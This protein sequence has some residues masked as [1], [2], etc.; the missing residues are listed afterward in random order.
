MIKD[1]FTLAIKN[2]RKRGI[3]SWL[4]LLGIIIGVAVVVSLVFLGNGLKLAVMNQFGMDTTE[5]ISVQAGGLSAFGP[6]GTGV[7]NPLTIKDLEEI[8]KLSSVKKAIRRNIGSV[9]TKF[10]GKTTISFVTNVPLEERR[11]IQEIGNIEIEKG[12][13]FEKSDSRKV[14]LGYNF[15]VGKTSLTDKE[16]FPGN[17]MTINDEKYEVIG[18]TKR[19]GSFIQDN[20]IFMSNEDMKR[21]INYEDNI[22]IIAVQPENAQRM[23]DSV[24]D[25]ERILRKTRNVKEGEEDF[26]VST[27]EASLAMIN[28]IITGVQ[29]FIILVAAISIFVGIV[30]IINTMTT[31]VLER[32]RDI[33][34]MKA[35]GAKNSQVFLQFFVEAGMLGLVGGIIGVLFGTL[36]GWMGILALENFLTTDLKL[37]VDWII[38]FSVFIGSFLIGGAAGIAPAIKAANQNPVEALK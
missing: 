16:I 12:R 3:R 31:S 20:V 7:T 4:T 37:E 19:K 14:V 18:I 8:E 27:P 23:E 38:T 13:F 25:I 9:E 34:I 2:L 32:R 21:A 33:G 11:F 1:Y 24:R 28:D 29:I 5:I 10:D 35:I 17:R 22:D 26:Q 30:G 36:V 6:P 15:L